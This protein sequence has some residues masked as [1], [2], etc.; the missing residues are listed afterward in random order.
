M[1]LVWPSD[2]TTWDATTGEVSFRRPDGHITSVRN[3]QD[4]VLGGGGSSEAEDGP[5]DEEWIGQL[6][7]LASPAPDCMVETRWLV[8]DVH[9][10]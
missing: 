6:D 3:G 7:W 5:S 1:L 2:R 10:D 4:V 8:S 9:A